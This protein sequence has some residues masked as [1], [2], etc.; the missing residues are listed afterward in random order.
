MLEKI[1]VV[2]KNKKEFKS[3]FDS[4]VNVLVGESGSGKSFVLM[5]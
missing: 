3:S 2:L 4:E 5:Q 1:T